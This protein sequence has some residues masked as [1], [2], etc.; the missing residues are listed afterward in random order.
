MKLS[1]AMQYVNPS[2]EQAS[3]DAKA[4][5]AVDV[6]VKTGQMYES[7]GHDAALDYI[8]TLYD[9][10]LQAIGRAVIKACIAGEKWCIGQIGKPS[11]EK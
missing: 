9:G 3:V 7:G 10:G 6:I 2:F 1:D 8:D 4:P 11:E 5:Q